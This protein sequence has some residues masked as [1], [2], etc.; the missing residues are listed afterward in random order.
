MSGRLSNAEIVAVT[1]NVLFYCSYST[2][3]ELI[4][5]GKVDGIKKM[6]T[7]HFD[8]KETVQAFETSR[9]GHGGAIKVMIHCQ[10]QEQE[11][12]HACLG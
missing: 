4:A 11:Q 6:I 7:H 12:Y 9:Y 2:A 10:P 1:D 5:S 3:L 8:I